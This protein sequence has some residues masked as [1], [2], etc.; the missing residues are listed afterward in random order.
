MIHSKWNQ[1]DV[2]KIACIAIIYYLSDYIV[3][4]KTWHFEFEYILT[5]NSK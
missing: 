1:N 5:I 4:K 2:H 3:L